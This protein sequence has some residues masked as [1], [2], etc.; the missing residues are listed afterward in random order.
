M[1]L[2]SAI[3]VGEIW[4]SAD[5]R[6]KLGEQAEAAFLNKATSLGLSVAKPWGDS[7]RYDLLVDSGRRVW[8]GAGE[9]DAICGGAAFLDHGAGLHGGVYGG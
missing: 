9:I 4:A 3:W 7:E 6:K 2:Q 8:R 1:E 5:T